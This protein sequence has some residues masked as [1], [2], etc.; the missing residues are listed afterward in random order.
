MSNS[1]STS[2]VDVQR[3]DHT[4]ISDAPSKVDTSSET[5]LN[6]IT[7]KEVDKAKPY[8]IIILTKVIK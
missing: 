5:N 6:T 8:R 4:D 3:E 7:G 1:K 2:F